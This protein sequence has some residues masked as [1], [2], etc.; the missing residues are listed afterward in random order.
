MYPKRVLIVS[1]NWVTVGILLL[2]YHMASGHYVSSWEQYFCIYVLVP[3][4]VVTS[5]S[6]S[7]VGKCF[8]ILWLLLIWIILWHVF[9]TSS[10]RSLTIAWGHS[11]WCS[12]S[13]DKLCS[14]LHS[15]CSHSSWIS[16]WCV[17]LWRTWLF[18][19]IICAIMAGPISILGPRYLPSLIGH[20]DMVPIH[21]ETSP[22]QTIQTHKTGL[23]W[24]SY[25]T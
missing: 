10:T 14:A 15:S 20:Q 24:M 1:N 19:L 23:Y 11:L 16:A 5:G 9:C 4:F 25:W 8:G 21:I 13:M 17:D 12:H 7:K 18:S 6:S 22:I 3:P 2:M